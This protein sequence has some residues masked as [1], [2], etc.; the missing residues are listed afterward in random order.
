MNDGVN[1]KP[2]TGG[3]M[4]RNNS[5]SVV[6]LRTDVV[7]ISRLTAFFSILSLLFANSSSVSGAILPTDRSAPELGSTLVFL[8][9]IRFP[10]LSSLLRRAMGFVMAHCPTVSFFG[11][12]SNRSYSNV[13]PSLFSSFPVDHREWCRYRFVVDSNV[14]CGFYVCQC[15]STESACSSPC[16]CA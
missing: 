5:S 14:E 2:F 12:S 9:S 7:R 16:S 13:Q 10:S 3:V 4:Y 8:G 11:W 15:N 1:S 6:P